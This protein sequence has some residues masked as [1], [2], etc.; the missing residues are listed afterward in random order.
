MW[1]MAT[2]MIVE[3]L[4]RS[5]WKHASLCGR[6]LTP[7]LRNLMNHSKSKNELLVNLRSDFEARVESDHRKDQADLPCDHLIMR[8]DD[9]SWQPDVKFQLYR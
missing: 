1:R 2:M 8:T 6:P 7:F 9:S 5:Y 3:S 4:Q